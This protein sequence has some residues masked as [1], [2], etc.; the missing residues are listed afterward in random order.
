MPGK[1]HVKCAVVD[2]TALVGSGNL[3]DDAFNRNMELGLAVNDGATAD[4]IY[5]HFMA[6]AERG[7]L[8]RVGFGSKKSEES[9][10][11]HRVN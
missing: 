1:L 7:E 6:L 4:A 9:A 2:G 10:R 8:R 3:T 5:D 11:H